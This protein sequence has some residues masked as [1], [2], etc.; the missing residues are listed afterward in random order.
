[1]KREFK[2]LGKPLENGLLINPAHL[3]RKHGGF[4]RRVDVV[5]HT[6]AGLVL[7]DYH[8]TLRH[9]LHITAVGQE[10]SVCLCLNIV[11]IELQPPIPIEQLPTSFIQ[12]LRVCKEERGRVCV[13]E[14]GVVCGHL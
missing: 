3:Q 9:P 14:R 2:K 12:L 10:R 8:V 4:V 13:C 7:G 1:M 6:E 11:E 5:P